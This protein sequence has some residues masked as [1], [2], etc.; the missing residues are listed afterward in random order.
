M[1]SRS[2]RVSVSRA[3]AQQSDAACLP[4]TCY[5]YSASSL[6]LSNL[7]A[8]G[9]YG[10]AHGAAG[11][12]APLAGSPPMAPYMGYQGFHPGPRQAAYGGMV[13]AS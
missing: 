13:R 1:S 7:M 5:A 2:H 6:K 12:Q 4:W 3:A 10:G 9:V 8:G 11:M